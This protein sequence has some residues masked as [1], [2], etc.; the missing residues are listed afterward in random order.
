MDPN[1]RGAPSATS[2]I[3]LPRVVGGAAIDGLL[4]MLAFGCDIT[5]W[6][7]GVPVPAFPVLIA[8][9]GIIG[10]PGRRPFP[11]FSPCDASRVLPPGGTAPIVDAAGSLSLFISSVAGG[12]TLGAPSAILTAF[13][14]DVPATDPASP[15]VTPTAFPAFIPP[16]GASGFPVEAVEAGLLPPSFISVL[17]KLNAD[18]SPGTC[19]KSFGLRE[20]PDPGMLSPSAGIGGTIGVLPPKLTAAALSV[21]AAIVPLGVNCGVL[22]S[23]S[24]AAEFHLGGPALRLSGNACVQILVSEEPTAL[25]KELVPALSAGEP[26]VLAGRPLGSCDGP[27]SVA[28]FEPPPSKE[29]RTLTMGPDCSPGL[30]ALFL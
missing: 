25:T 7:L 14:P 8:A 10:P 18:V 27:F 28:L 4:M 1:P 24:L 19:P 21:L 17:P 16:T 22:G 26:S 11:D 12:G 6:L 9:A 23:T 20:V 30:R 2:L 15:S 13:V 29:G 5:P 3:P